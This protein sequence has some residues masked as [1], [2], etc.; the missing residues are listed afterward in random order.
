MKFITFSGRNSGRTKSSRRQE[1]ASPLLL[2]APVPRRAY[3]RFRADS[4]TK[5][6]S[7]TPTKKPKEPNKKSVYVRKEFPETWLWTEEMVR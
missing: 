5:A 1:L 4:H 6:P 2:A 3:L 7:I